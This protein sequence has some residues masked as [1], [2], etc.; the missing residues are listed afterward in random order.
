MLCGIVDHCM[1]IH[2]QTSCAQLEAMADQ[3]PLD[4]FDAMYTCLVERQQF[5]AGR[6]KDGLC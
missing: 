4:Q 5:P 6:T 3:I 1:C 2:S